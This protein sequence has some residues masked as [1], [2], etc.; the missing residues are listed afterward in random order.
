MGLAL[1]LGLVGLAFAPPAS[2]PRREITLTAQS[3]PLSTTDPKAERAGSLRFLG[4][5]VL[6]SQDP[7]FGGLSG[8]TVEAKDGGWRILAITDQ[9]STFS[10]RLVL[11]GARLRGVEQAAIEPLVDLDG[12]PVAGKSMGDAE[13]ITRLSDGRVLVGFERRHRIW[14]YGPGLT[15]SARAFETPRKL[16]DAPSNGGLESLANWPDGR[17]LAITEHLETKD[18]HILGF[19]FQGRTWAQVE[20]TPSAAGF[21]PA[22]A[23]V[24]PDGDLLV[25]ERYWSAR[26]PL[27]LSSRIIRVKGDGVRSGATLRGERMAELTAPLTAE[28]FEGITSFKNAQGRTQ[29]LMASDDN[30]N[31]VQ[32]TLL[33]SFELPD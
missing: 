7:R 10:G 27:R 26:S 17:I 20:W 21:E 9:G 18:G 6:R 31:G 25:L 30:F 33:F 15:G 16:A 11:D 29:L 14:A 8:L 24:L 3:V 12:R 22:D 4:G 28:N 5:L 2:R 23:T 19:L 1:A 13:S 32:R